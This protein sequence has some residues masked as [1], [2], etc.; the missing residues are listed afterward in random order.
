M[1]QRVVILATTVQEIRELTDWCH[2]HGAEVVGVAR[3]PDSA[4]AM[5]EHHEADRLLIARE[6]QWHDLLPDVRVLG[7]PPPDLR[8][9][10]RLR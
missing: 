3:D 7:E 8:R 10:R 2:R 9:P 4:L 6:D 1:A 5:V